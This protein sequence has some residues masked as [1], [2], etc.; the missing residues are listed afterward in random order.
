MHKKNKTMKK[1]DFI[2]IGVLPEKILDVSSVPCFIWN[3]D[4]SKIV[5]SKER[6]DV[7][8]RDGRMVFDIKP[9]NRMAIA[10]SYDKLDPN[11]QKQINQSEGIVIVETDYSEHFRFAFVGVNMYEPNKFKFI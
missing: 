2:A 4:E 11:V 3:I 6:Y 10:I 7:F 1:M 8:E 5:S 9:G